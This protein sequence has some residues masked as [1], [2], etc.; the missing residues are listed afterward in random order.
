M[1]RI[2]H[3]YW[4]WEDYLN[5]MYR[6]SVDKAKI[7]KCSK[8]LSDTECF[9]KALEMVLK[10][11]VFSSD[12]NLSNT[13]QNRLAWLGAAA[14]CISIGAN[15]KTTRLGWA[16]LNE[17]QRLKAN[18]TARKYVKKYERENSQIY[19]DMGTKMLL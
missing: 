6:G 15:E 4:L 12:V 14:C 9:S 7:N 8:L 18:T 2:Y 10:E 19:R 13:S 1:N 16:R 11:W 3:P 17:Q 5:G